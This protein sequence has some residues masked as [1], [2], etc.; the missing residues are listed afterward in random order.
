MTFKTTKHARQG[1]RMN[2]EELREAPGRDA[3]KTS[4]DADD[5]PLKAGDSEIPLHPLGG[6]LHGMVQSPDHPHEVEYFAETL[7]VSGFLHSIT[8]T[9]HGRTLLWFLADGRIVAS[10]RSSSSISF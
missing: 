9:R 10:T 4:N 3:G 2:M 1:A 7:F 6:P 8:A 5:E